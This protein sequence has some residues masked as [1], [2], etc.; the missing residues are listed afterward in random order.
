MNIIGRISSGDDRAFDELYCTY[1]KGFLAL[2]RK[3]FDVGEE[4]A[5]DLYQEACAALYNNIRSKKVTEDNLPA[6]KVH[7]YLISTGK[8]ILYN[9]RRKRQV[10]LVFE[11]DL[12]MRFHG[13]EEEMGR[14]PIENLAAL[15]KVEDESYD[16]E[17][18]DK[19]FVIRS[20]VRDIPEPC[21][22]LLDLVVFQ[23]K[24]HKEVAEIMHYA[25]TDTV[26]SQRWRCM[27]KLREL[28]LS[29]FKL[30][31]YER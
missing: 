27:Q 16:K 25:N 29:R 17:Y 18:D 12:V 20:S 15:D 30:L 4:D 28:V 9:K 3:C 1:R 24:S 13:T 14:S 26:S 19:L 6:A 8:W 31:G 10:P 22:R 5:L 11:T 23:G 7:P 2:F 21:S